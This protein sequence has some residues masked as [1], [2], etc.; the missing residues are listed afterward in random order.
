MTDENW[1][2]IRRLIEGQEVELGP[3]FGHQVRNAPR[4]LLFTLARYKFAARMLPQGRKARVLEIG[5]SEGIG[6][7][8]LGEAGHEVLGVD[9]DADAIARAREVMAKPNLRFECADFI[10]GDFGAGSFDAVVSLDVIEHIRPE[11]EAAFLANIVRHLTPDGICVIGTPNDT[12]SRYASAASQIGHVNMFTAER[13]GETL[14]R[15]FVHVFPFGMN[16]E[17][18]HTGFPAMCHYLLALACT[19]RAA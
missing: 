1:A 13:L 16:D 15:H 4:H 3:Y 19:P 18:L 6:T 5:C 14:A 2:E 11:D 7:G 12:A 17:V 10:G 9:G 8:L